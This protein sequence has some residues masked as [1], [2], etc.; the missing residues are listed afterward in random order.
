MVVLQTVFA[1]L[2]AFNAA[3]EPA[4]NKQ[5][6]NPRA[7][8]HLALRKSELQIAFDGKPVASYVFE[9]P[10]VKR[11]FFAHI[12]TTGGVQ[13]TRAFPPVKGKDAV[14][15]PTMHPGLWLAF[16][17]LGGADFWR[18]KGRVVH[19]RFVGKITAG[20]SSATFAT[21]NRYQRPDGSVI[22][23]QT[24]TYRFKKLAD[25][26]QMN[27]DAR[28]ASKERFAFGVQEEMG[29][30]IRV[31]TPLTVKNGGNILASHGGK[32]EKGTWGRVAN[33]WDYFGTAKGKRV[34]LLVMSHPGNGQ[35]W[36]H[37]RDYGCLVANPFPVDRRENRGKL[38]VV[39]PGREHR[40]RFAVIVHE[41][42]LK[43][44]FDRKAAYRAYVKRK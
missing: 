9:H 22:C 23:R 37:S 31:A 2:A 10:K 43:A 38:T 24:T 28:F 8:F 4:T 16:G 19:E 35:V 3:D 26:W 6:G 39:E 25:G 13:V 27:L 42:D 11:P 12:K 44:R 5:W 41:G 21:R 29:L 40:L 36:S 34:G 32:N 30:G 7:G 15:H 14:D 20:K 18:N 33:W 17:K 1:L